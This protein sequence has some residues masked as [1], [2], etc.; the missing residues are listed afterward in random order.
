MKKIFILFF[1]LFLLSTTVA[2]GQVGTTIEYQDNLTR[3]IGVPLILAYAGLVNGKHSYTETVDNIT[4][5]WSGTRW[6]INCCGDILLAHS[7][8]MTVGI[9][10]PTGTSDP[11]DLWVLDDAATGFVIVNGSG[12]TAVL[13]VELTYFTIAKQEKSLELEWQTASELNNEKFEIEMSQDGRSFQ[14]LGEVKGNGTTSAQSDYS[15]PITNPSL[16]LSYY[17]LK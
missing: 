8:A 4:V 1:L 17:R 2:F 16:G 12:S 11:V 5:A 7:D 10:P 15:F 3:P 6:E 13:P 14:K 9:S